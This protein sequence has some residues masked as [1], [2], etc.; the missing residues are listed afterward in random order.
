MI[1]DQEACRDIEE[2]AI[3]LAKAICD[4][5]VSLDGANQIFANALRLLPMR[6]SMGVCAPK[7]QLR[8]AERQERVREQEQR[9]REQLVAAGNAKLTEQ[10]G[11]FG[12]DPA[13][14]FADRLPGT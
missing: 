2:R 8:L 4:A 1:N 5:S 14:V 3:S 12:I 11:D 9:Q 6:V 10:L 13:P 7:F